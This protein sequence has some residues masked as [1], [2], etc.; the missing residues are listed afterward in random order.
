MNNNDTNQ[1][2]NTNNTTQETPTVI[3]PQ[4]VNIEQ[5]PQEVEQVKTTDTNTS[6][7]TT[8]NNNPNSNSTA[9]NTT[10]NN[11]PTSVQPEGNK[12]KSTKKGYP[13]F[14]IVLMILLFAFV[15][16]LPNIT[17]LVN[18]YKSQKENEN[19]LKSGKMVCTISNSSDTTNLTYSLEFDYTKYKLKKSQITTTSRLS[20]TAIDTSPLTERQDSCLLLKEVLDSNDIGMSASCSVSAT[21]QTTIQQI[22]YKKL[23]LDFISDNIAECEGF[24][25]E[26]EL[27]QNVRAIE[28]SLTNSGY[29]CQKTE[30]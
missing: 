15:F 9:N 1:K 20:D 22:D 14:L 4:V 2:N 3:K 6:N 23:D 24:Y 21:V 17:D 18:E 29:K 25:P 10:T 16:F 8:V 5:Q 11:I 12:D 26:Y 7:N 13:V 30:K 27:N 28:K 19:A